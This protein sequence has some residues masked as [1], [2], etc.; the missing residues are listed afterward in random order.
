[1]RFKV[2]PSNLIMGSRQGGSF[3]SRLVQARTVGD[4][5]R[6]IL[7]AFLENLFL[8]LVLVFLAYSVELVDFLTRSFDLD[9]WGGIRPRATKNLHGVLTAHFLHGDLDHIVGN[10]LP[11]LLFGACVLIR[12]RAVFWKVSIFVAL[13]GGG[14]LWALGMKGNI[15]VG[16]SLVIF[17]YLGFLLSRGIFER[18]AFWIILSIVT[19]PIY[20]FMFL[21][22]LPWQKEVSWEGHL[23]GFI[24]GIIA[25]K[26][27][28]PQSK[29]SIENAIDLT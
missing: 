9:N 4:R 26:I 29:R 13:V 21:N 24:A 23:Y 12:G 7:G 27:L 20:S 3:S 10:T 19:L 28:V 16:A 25:A 18:N 15:H 1:M 5:F 6:T 14:L 11:F 17:G 22:L 2:K 8:L